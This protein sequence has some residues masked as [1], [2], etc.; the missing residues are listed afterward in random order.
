M[1]NSIVVIPAYNEE[2]TI[3]EVVSRSL[4]YADVCVVN[5]GSKD[6]TEE[7]VNSIH[8]VKCITHT[9]N[10]HIPKAIIDG[11]QYAFE[12][13]YN[14]V[15][16]MDAGLSHSPEELAGFINAP[17]S[18]LVLGVRVQREN[19]P[20]YRKVLSKAATLLISFSLR[21]FGSNLP[22][23][24]FAD[25]TSGFRRYSRKSVELLLN[26]QMKA[27]SFDFHTEALMFVYRNGLKISELPITYLFTNSS[28]N[29]SVILDSISMLLDFLFRRRK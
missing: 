16:T 22:K 20:I 23:A 8:G 12:H 19:V 13:G 17:Y 2:L 28:L 18:D 27:K 4:K 7:I 21:P 25:A 6:R 26:R 29:K 15:I 10:T 14:F 5:D 9:S 24:K 3:K 1:K 11:M